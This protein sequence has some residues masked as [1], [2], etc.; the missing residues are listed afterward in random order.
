VPQYGHLPLLL[1]PDRAPLS[2]RHGAVTI[3][4]LREAGFLPQ[5]VVN[6]LAL[7]GGVLGGRQWWI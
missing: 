6:Y 4:E 7:L 1:G 3:R 5:A 2:K